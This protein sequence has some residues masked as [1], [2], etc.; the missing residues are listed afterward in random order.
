MNIDFIFALIDL[1]IKEEFQFSNH[2]HFNII[3]ENSLQK[4]AL[5]EPKIISTYI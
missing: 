4:V 1:N 2:T 3:L 5:V